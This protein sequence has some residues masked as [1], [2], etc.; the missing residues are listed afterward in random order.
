MAKV[1]VYD[2]KRIDEASLRMNPKVYVMNIMQNS[3][4]L[5]GN[6]FY[7]EYG[8]TRAQ[9]IE[10]FKIYFE[11][12][13]LNGDAEGTRDWMIAIVDL[14]KNG[15]DIALVCACAPKPCHGDV[16]KLWIETMAGGI[17]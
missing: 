15:V 6:P 9:R 3:G 8:L 17:L 1:T 5:F 14:Y 13:M 10:K 7:K 11:D 2:Y 16:I 4:S 12:K